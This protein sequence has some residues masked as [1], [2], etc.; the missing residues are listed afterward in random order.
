[1]ALEEVFSIK[2]FRSCLLGMEKAL[3]GFFIP[4][5]IRGAGAPTRFRTLLVVVV[6]LCVSSSVSAQNGPWKKVEPGLHVGEFRVPHASLTKDPSLTI[7]KMDPGLY[8]L[9]L[10]CASE[11]GRVRMTLKDWCQKHGLIAGINAGMYLEDGIK[12]VGYMKNFDHVNNPRVNGSYKAM[13]AFNR[14][15]PGV[16]QT[17]IID[18]TCQD[19]ELLRPKY[20]TF[21]QSIRM[22]GCRQENVWAKQSKRSSIAALGIDKNGEVLFLFTEAP[23]SGHDF[24]NLLLSLPIS[25]RNALY[26]EGGPPANLYLST[27]DTDLERVGMIGSDPEEEPFRT[28]L[29]LLPNIIGIARK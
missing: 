14:L 10:L 28:A 11:Y 26:L 7:V 15:D 21:V 27:S 29:R 1:M 19:F 23:Y 13:L 20:Q 6:C 24:I 17:Q 9:K 25:I 3:T 8:T 2:A 16:A 18:L 4:L 5:W 22:I 12:S